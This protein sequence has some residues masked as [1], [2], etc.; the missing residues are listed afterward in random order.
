MHTEKHVLLDQINTVIRGKWVDSVG[1]LV[2]ESTGE[3]PRLHSIREHEEHQLAQEIAALKSR[4]QALEYL[5]DQLFYVLKYILESQPDLLSCN[6]QEI[7]TKDLQLTSVPDGKS[8]ECPCPT[9]REKDILHLLMQGMCA[10]EIAATLY[11]SETTV[12]THK[13]N[14]KDKF[15]AKNTAELISKAQQVSREYR[16]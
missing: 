6:Q 9:P 3:R 10:K 13:R 14:L 2:V 15:R 5:N 8:P 12:V 1:E 7:T 16:R 11:I 4:V